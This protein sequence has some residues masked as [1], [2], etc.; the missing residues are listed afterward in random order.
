MPAKNIPTIQQFTLF[1]VDIY[2]IEA[3]E[4]AWDDV[5]LYNSKRTPQELL[6]EL[7]HAALGVNLK[8]PNSYMRFNYN[9]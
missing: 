9:K 8:P 2:K 3:K 7:W 1:V 5:E 4:I 6:F